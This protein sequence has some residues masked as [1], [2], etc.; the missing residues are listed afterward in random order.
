MIETEKYTKYCNQIYGRFL[1]THPHDSSRVY[2]ATK[3]LYKRV[4]NEEPNP[5]IWGAGVKEKERSSPDYK[6]VNII[7][8]VT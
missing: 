6:I 7:G 1:H 5:R 4:F 3:V 2:S 8:C